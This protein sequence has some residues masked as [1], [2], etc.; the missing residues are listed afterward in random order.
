MFFIG[1]I[2]RYDSTQ[3]IGTLMFL[4]G[5]KQEFKVQDWVDTLNEP[6]IGQKVSY[7]SNQEGIKIKV[8]SEEDIQKAQTQNEETSP[9]LSSQKLKNIDDYIEYF[10]EKGFKLAKDTTNADIRTLSFRY[11]LA[12]TGEFG[13]AIVKQ[14]GSKIEVTQTLNGE[15]I[16][17]SE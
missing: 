4:D 12:S 2:Y 16:P 11:Y 17:F 7:E 10:T 15:A 6:S 9:K 13:E 8:A 14:N 5:E 1:M 3:G